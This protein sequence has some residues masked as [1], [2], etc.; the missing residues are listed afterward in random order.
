MTSA[1]YGTA[2]ERVV[3]HMT[4]SSSK[5]VALGLAVGLLVAA[6]G[7]APAST[8]PSA[9]GAPTAVPTAAPTVAPYKA[10]DTIR[11]IVPTNPGGG[12]DTQARLMAPVL[13][14]TISA[15]AGVQV[16]VVVENVPGAGH[17]VGTLQV[18]RA[19]PDGKTFEIAASSTMLSPQV[20]GKT[21]YDVTKMTH[22]G[23][24]SNTSLAMIVKKDL[25]LPTR[26]F[27]GAMTRSQ[28][29]PFSVA[30][31]GLDEQLTLMAAV[32]N[33]G[34][35]AK[36]NQRL[37][38]FT[39]TGEVVAAVLRG[40]VDAG[41]TTTGALVSF[42]SD[43]KNNLEFL[44]NYNCTRESI[45]PNVTTI[46]EQKVPNADKACAVTGT[47]RLLLAPP[48][49]PAAT[50]KFLSDALKKTLEDPALVKQMTD[51]KLEPG[52]IGPEETTKTINS[53]LAAYEQNK[54]IFKK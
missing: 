39:G 20:L 27:N 8:A 46:V 45:V 35:G 28:T 41:V 1:V 13:E 36:F 3:M 31:G 5:G 22:L 12:F 54:D 24:V 33:Q 19:A 26:D 42:V 49:V 48:G 23:I 50:A 7:G 10:G 11:F 32:I 15:A 37:L 53:I 52:W 29:K 18:Y 51:A 9:T 47:Y 16:K 2:M 40:D 30:H 25:A 21:E 34:G 14:K 38:R 43:A 17:Q 4:R 6:C 44:A